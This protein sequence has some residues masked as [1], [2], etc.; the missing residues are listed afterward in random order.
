[1]PLD[2]IQGIEVNTV[3]TQIVQ[4]GMLKGFKATCN[5]WFASTCY[6]FADTYMNK[7]LDVQDLLSSGRQSSGLVIGLRF[8]WWC[9]SYSSHCSQQVGRYM[10]AVVYMPI[11]E[12][13]EYLIS[14][15][16][17][18]I[19]NSLCNYFSALQFSP[20]R[21]PK[22]FPVPHVYTVWCNWRWLHFKCQRQLYK[23][24]IQI[25]DS[26]LADLSVSMG[27]WKT[28]QSHCTW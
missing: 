12:H 10:Q 17:N 21:F 6:W 5:V 16:K 28:V 24:F 11:T 4:P 18:F 13:R 3:I 15:Y 20:V 22:L 19:H 7:A 27:D 26:G 25:K 9:R 1:M 8:S 14:F 23:C 2:C